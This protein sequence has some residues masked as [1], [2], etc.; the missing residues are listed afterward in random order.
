VPASRLAATCGGTPARVRAYLT[1]FSDEALDEFL[2]EAP[3]AQ[4]AYRCSVHCPLDDVP[5]VLGAIAP[6]GRLYTTLCEFQTQQIWPSGADA[7]AIVG[8]VGADGGFQLEVRLNRAPLP[9]EKMAG[10]LER[11]LGMDVSYAPL[12]PF[13]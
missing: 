9:E 13:P 11:L 8:L 12:P 6:A 10:E 4:P 2:A 5:E 3:G 7:S 1:G